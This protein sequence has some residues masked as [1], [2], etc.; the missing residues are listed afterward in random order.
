M[1]GRK[2]TPNGAR[3][4]FFPSF[5]QILTR[6]HWPKITACMIR[7]GTNVNSACDHQRADEYRGHGP[8]VRIH[9]VPARPPDAERKHHQRED[10]QQVDR[11]P[12]APQPDLMDPERAGGHERHQQDP[13]PAQRAMRQ[14]SLRRGQLHRRQARTPPWRQRRAAGSQARHRAVVRGSSFPQTTVQ[15]LATYRSSQSP[16]MLTSHN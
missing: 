15:P 2:T 7:P 10:R 3:E 11:A 9:L 1:R 13:D 12:R 4:R 14:R 16:P 8:A 5:F 6:R